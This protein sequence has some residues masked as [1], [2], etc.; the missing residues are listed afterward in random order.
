[1]TARPLGAIL[2]TSHLAA[3]ASGPSTAAFEP[4]PTQPTPRTNALAWLRLVRRGGAAVCAMIPLTLAGCNGGTEQSAS[5]R[6][7]TAAAPPAKPDLLLITVDTVRPDHLRCYGATRAH[8]PA[9]DRLAA[10]GVVFEEAFSPYPLTLPAHASIHTGLLPFEHGM[11]NNTVHVGTDSLVT[12][13][14]RLAA[15]G[16][17]TAAIVSA[18]VLDARFGL[19][20]GFEHYD[21]DLELPDSREP[22]HSQA[23]RRAAATTELALE[24]L[25]ARDDRPLFLWVHYFDAHAPYDPPAPYRGAGYDGEIG[26]MEQEIARLLLAVEGTGRWEQTG[27]VYAGDHGEAFGE[28]GER[29]HGFFIYDVTL[30]VPLVVKPPGPPVRPS[31]CD[32]PVGLIDV[33]PTLLRWAEIHSELPGVGRDLMTASPRGGP[34]RPLYAESLLPLVNHAAAPLASVRSD[35]WKFIAAPKPELYAVG[36]DPGEVHNLFDADPRRAEAMAQLLRAI[37][38]PEALAEPTSTRHTPPDRETAERLAALGYASTP[39]P[40]RGPRRADPKDVIR[41]VGHIE[42]GDRLRAAGDLAGA[43]NAYEQALQLDPR[44]WK[45]TW[46][47][48]DTRSD[49]GELGL[50]EQVL[51]RAL[52]LQPANYS[53]ALRLAGVLHDLGRTREGLTLCEQVLERFPERADARAMRAVMLHALGRTSQA[54]AELQELLTEQPDSDLAR[55]AM[56]SLFPD[57][58]PSDGGQR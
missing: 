55:S 18:F 1:M 27:I 37:H 41:L 5:A 17:A 15:D 20:Q 3:D 28:H 13:A 4:R 10:Q 57:P 54:R 21:D 45:A 36:D 26:S 14:E 56:E 12:L 11:R 35:G 39:A 19:S 24:R 29:Q 58:A 42:E 34:A 7:R 25:G 22:A 23:E 51:R 48:A 31:R 49:Q 43:A 40:S 8:T 52:E 6:S 44:E 16:Y 47:L 38:P 30:R 2:S 46:K 50:A 33:A 32:A 53:A 9:S